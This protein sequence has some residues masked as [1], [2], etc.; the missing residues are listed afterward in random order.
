MSAETQGAVGGAESGAATGAQVGG[1]WG[2]LIGGIAGGA[3]GAAGGS[4]VDNAMANRKNTINDY[5]AQLAALDMPRYADL[6]LAYQRYSA[7]QQLTPAQL[8]ALQ[9]AD[10]DITKL[11]QDKA[12]KSAQLEA[13]AGL[14][15]R[16][17]GGLSLQ[18]K[19]NLLDAQSQIDRQQS[20]AQKAIMQ[21][22]A[23][24]G[25]G[26]SGAELAQRLQA[27]QGGAQLAAQ[28]SLGIAG[29]AQQNAIQALKDSASMGRQ[30]GQDQLS[31]DAMKAQAAD[32]TRRRNLERLQSTMQYNIGNQ[33]QANLYNTQRANN[34]SDMNTQL[35]NTEQKQNKDLLWTDYQHQVGKLNNT[36]GNQ[37]G[38]ANE[39][40]QN[41]QN[42]AAGTMGLLNSAGGLLGGLKG[43][44][45]GTTDTGSQVYK[46]PNLKASD[47]INELD[48]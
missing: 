4:G 48:V 17:R 24:R 18:D 43:A 38:L 19:A 6:K 26:G 45:S 13:L 5:M 14:K 3:L 20:G 33:N 22:M 23:A 47:N 37:L 7:G 8:T 30:I 9:E 1:P 36:F 25:Q 21:N 29:Q 15:A 40:V 34:L 11:T 35:G 16:A 44:F 46:N 10:S 42:N 39:G 41:A 2:A 31:F 32:D 12:A 27:T 28:N